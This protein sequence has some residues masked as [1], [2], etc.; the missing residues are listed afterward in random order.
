MVLDT[1]KI[2]NTMHFVTTNNSDQQYLRVHIYSSQTKTFGR[3]CA[4]CPWHCYGEKTIITIL[5]DNVCHSRKNIKIK[6][7][8]IIFKFHININ[9]TLVPIYKIFS[10][11]IQHT[12]IS[13]N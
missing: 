11:L 12:N 5:P 1:L 13:I 4:E 8:F 3:Y 2:L 7:N 9:I 6:Q 10:F